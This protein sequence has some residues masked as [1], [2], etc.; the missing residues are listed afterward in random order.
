MT[1]QKTD[2]LSTALIKAEIPS[3]LCLYFDLN[4]SMVLLSGEDKN[5][6][7]EFKKYV[8]ENPGSRI[9]ISGHSDR[10]G[11]PQIKLKISSDRSE[12]AQQQ[13]IAAGIDA[14]LITASGKSDGEPATEDN[15]PEGNAKNRRAEIQIK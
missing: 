5:R 4:K 9:I 14:S 2:T 15:T 3:M 6:I 12:Y 7:D 10:T 8:T 11:T 13:L 1:E